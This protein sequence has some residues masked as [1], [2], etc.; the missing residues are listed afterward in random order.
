MAGRVAIVGVGVTAFRPVSPEL[1]YRELMYEAAV[2]AYADAG[3]DPRTDVDSFVT[4][5]EDFNEGTSIFDEY[6]PDQLGAMLRPMHTITADGLNS[7]AAAH[8]QIQTGAFDVVVVEAHSKA[9]NVLTPDQVTAYAMDPVYTRPLRFHPNAIAGLEMS[10]FLEESRA[11]REQ[12]GLVTVKEPAQRARP[13]LWLPT[14]QT[15]HWRRCWT[16]R[17]RSLP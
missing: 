1:S 15:T 12:C 11:T 17:L 7:V 8:M 14:G 9:S 2:R 3:I 10:R 6:T 5:A 4:S 16:P 13:T